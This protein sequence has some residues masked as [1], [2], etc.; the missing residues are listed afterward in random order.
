MGRTARVLSEL[1]L[2]VSEIM[3]IPID[4][5]LRWSINQCPNPL[6]TR[7]VAAMTNQIAK[8]PAI[9]EY[10]TS[11]TQMFAKNERFGV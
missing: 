8:L 4:F 6:L 10:L 9:S 2:D 11:L 1:P 5:N 3:V 7:W